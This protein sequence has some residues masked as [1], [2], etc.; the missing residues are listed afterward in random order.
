M[1]HK[2]IQSFDFHSCRRILSTSSTQLPT[3][4]VL[5]LFRQ[6]S[7]VFL[8]YPMH[9]KVVASTIVL[10]AVAPSAFSAPLPGPAAEVHSELEARLKLPSGTLGSLGTSLG[11]GLLTGGAVSGL[12][13]LLGEDDDTPAARW[14]DPINCLLRFRLDKISAVPS[15]AAEGW[16]PLSGNSSAL[17]RRAS[18]MCSRTP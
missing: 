3:A 1:T 7:Q 10:L 12:L 16:E 15:K 18:R 17:A 5:N 13:G 8:R 14:V 9:S 2:Q 11:K 6:I 4:P